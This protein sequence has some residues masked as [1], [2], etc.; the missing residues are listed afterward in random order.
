[1]E[2]FFIFVEKQ[3][4]CCTET[5]VHAVNS[6]AACFLVFSVEFLIQ[7]SKKMQCI[8]TLGG[9]KCLKT[10]VVVKRLLNQL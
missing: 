2:I 3:K 9:I 4:I 5:V 7:I 10:S 8:A 1:M 6:L